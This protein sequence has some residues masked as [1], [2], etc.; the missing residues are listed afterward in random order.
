MNKVTVWSVIGLGL[1][2]ASPSLASLT[3]FGHTTTSSSAACIGA[4][5][6]GGLGQL[7]N[8]TTYLLVK[9]ESAT[10]SVAFRLGAGALAAAGLN[11]AGSYTLSPGVSISLSD[12]A[13][14]GSFLSCIGV[15]ADPVTLVISSR[16]GG[17]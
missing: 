3:T 5:G 9:N 10:D 12:P 8:G 15:G 16:P 2:W 1:A 7:P 14:S 6:D 11:S 17:F 4:I 13:L